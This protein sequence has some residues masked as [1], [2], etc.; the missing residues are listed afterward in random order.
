MSRPESGDRRVC[1]GSTV[2]I[3]AVVP[4]SSSSIGLTPWAQPHASD[5][6]EALRSRPRRRPRPRIRP[7]GVMEYWSVGVLR[8][9]GIAPRVRGVGNAFRAYLACELPRAQALGYG[10]EPLRGETRQMPAPLL[11]LESFCNS[12]EFAVKIRCQQGSSNEN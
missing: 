1:S 3:C 4:T 2:L 11:N 8:Q 5:A 9:L 6:R 7:R 12:S 10:L